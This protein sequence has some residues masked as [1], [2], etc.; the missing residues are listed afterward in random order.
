VA[1]LGG[2]LSQ[3]QGETSVL[4]SLYPFLPGGL[5]PLIGLTPLVLLADP[6]AP[7]PPGELTDPDVIPPNV[8]YV[9]Y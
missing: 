6:L 7:P 2:T 1:C 9:D 5:P 8:S 4:G 3:Q